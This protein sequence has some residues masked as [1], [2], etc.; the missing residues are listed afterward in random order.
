MVTEL[1]ADFPHITSCDIRIGVL[2]AE[3]D[4]WPRRDR[5]VLLDRARELLRQG[6]V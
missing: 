4:I 5:Y 2:R 1:L 3:E 6:K